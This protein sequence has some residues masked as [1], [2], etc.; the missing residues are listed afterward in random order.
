MTLELGDLLVSSGALTAEQLRE[1]LVF[2]RNGDLTL[3]EALLKLALLDEASLYRAVAKQNGMP[4]VNLDKGRIPQAIL[5]RVPAEVATEQG[6]LP[7]MEK[8]G[9]L[10]VAIDDPFKRILADQLS[11][12]IGGEVVCALASPTAHR[13]AVARYFGDGGEKSVAASMGTSD[14]LLQTRRAGEPL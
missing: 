9:K 2:Q 13:L 7:L 1:A 11:F 10:V 12:V 14:F 8:G 6:I 5:D 4:F 3:P